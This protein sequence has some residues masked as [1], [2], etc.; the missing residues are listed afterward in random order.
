MRA[1]GAQFTNTF[2]PMDDRRNVATR[3]TAWQLEIEMKVDANGT[4]RRA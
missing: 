3:P 4:E 1:A 2:L